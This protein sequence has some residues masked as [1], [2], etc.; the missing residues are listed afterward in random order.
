MLEGGRGREREGGREALSACERSAYVTEEGSQ[1]ATVCVRGLLVEVMA[2]L[3]GG[4][5]DLTGVS[6]GWVDLLL[7]ERRVP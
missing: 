4:H 2:L 5:D 6:H 1:S 3:A 7:P